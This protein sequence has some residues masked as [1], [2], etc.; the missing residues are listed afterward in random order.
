MWGKTVQKVGP[1]LDC[2]NCSQEDRVAGSAAG[3]LQAGHQP[4]TSNTSHGGPEGERGVF[5]GLRCV[6]LAP[7]VDSLAFHQPPAQRR[8]IWSWETVHSVQFSSVAQLCLTLRPHELKH[9]RPPCPS[10]T[11]RVH[12]NPCPLS[13]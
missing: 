7:S 9:A 4:P 12:S 1:E 13:Q 5:L 2:R 8:A 6:P 3:L 11:P 10:P